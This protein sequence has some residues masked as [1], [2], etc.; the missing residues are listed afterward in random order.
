[1]W[2]L[3]LQKSQN[4]PGLFPVALL[5]QP[6]RTFRQGENEDTEKAGE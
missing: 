3:V 1:M 5:A 6:P 4:L 2:I